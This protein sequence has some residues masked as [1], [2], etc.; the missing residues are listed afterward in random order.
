[1]GIPFGR[2][3]LLKRIAAGGMGEVFLARQAGL[4][5]FEKLLVVKVLL[6][7]LVED[8]EFIT[9]FLDE[10]RIAARLNHPNVAQIFDLGEV[11]GAYYIAMEYIH[12]DDVVKVWR[13]ARAKG[14]EMPMALV[15][16][17]AA[18]AA[19]GLDY[20]HKATD[21]NNRPL[22]LVHR[23]VS[24]QNILVTFDGGVKLIDFGVAKAAGRS[25]HTATGTLKGKYSYMSPEQAAGAEIDRRSD[26]FALGVVLYE[27]ATGVRLFKRET[28]MATLKAVGECVVPRVS[29]KNP[30]VDPQLEA[31]ILK[32]LAKDAADRFQDAQEMRLALE[33]W[34][35]ATR[36]QGSAAHLA[37]FMQSLYAERLAEERAEGKPF[38]D[39]E[40]T[41][42]SIFRSV[43]SQLNQAGT[44]RARVGTGAG[45][46]S[47]AT[48]PTEP[49]GPA[50]PAA[51]SNRAALFAGIGVGV[52][53][54]AAAGYFLFQGSKST[55]VEPVANLAQP[56]ATLNLVTRPA[57][58]KVKLDGAEVGTTP[59]LGHPLTA[60]RVAKIEISLAGYK[61]FEQQVPGTGAQ[62]LNLALEP[63]APPPPPVQEQ[64]ELALVSE[65]RGATVKL[66]E[67]VLG[68]TPLTY[69]HARS[70]ERLTFEFKLNGFK[71]TSKTVESRES[72]EVKVVLARLGGGMAKGGKTPPKDDPLDIKD[73]R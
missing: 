53:A 70:G 59:L 62:N 54:L 29:E 36:K 71:S 43:G 45:Q 15:G 14:K 72:G 38:T 22:G 4:E 9:M 63:E 32:S 16:R 28:E 56:S 12:G 27:M 2:Y 55:S 42:S 35:V 31:V 25:S 60:G 67:S 11:N 57:G 21:S 48:A 58:A 1:M 5:G 69:R 10:A 39:F 50:I 34:L 7:H 6:P 66:G 47:S 20:A 18:D 65:P 8:Q 49:V 37:A 41:P 13:A 26:V 64:V 46:A 23:D 40:G 33:D 73:S 52:L 51:K 68:A 17:I 19:A 30:D 44:V 3:E 24:P 61:T